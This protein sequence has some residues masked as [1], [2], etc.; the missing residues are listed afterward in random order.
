[1]PDVFSLL[2][3]M[4]K[5]C[6]GVKS[7]KDVFWPQMGLLLTRQSRGRGR[8]SLVNPSQQ[9]DSILAIQFDAHVA[10]RELE[11]VVCMENSR[12]L[13]VCGKVFLF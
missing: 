9:R 8:Q 3:G 11:I 12:F 5:D 2:Q 4:K 1:M 13:L 10:K 6:L 7:C